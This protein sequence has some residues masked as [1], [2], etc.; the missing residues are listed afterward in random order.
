MKDAKDGAG[1][2]MAPVTWDFT[3]AAPPP[4]PPDQGPGGPVAIVTSSANPYSKYLAEILRTEG[5]NEFTT[6]DLS[7]LSAATLSDFDVVVLGS[8]NVSATQVTALTDWVNA[9]GNLIALKPDASL[10]SLLGI[11]ATGAGPAERR[12]P[13]GRQRSTAG[14]RGHRVDHDAVPRPGRP[15]HACPARRRWR[16]CTRTPPSAT[17]NPAVTLRSVGTNGGQAAAFTYD[18]PASIVAMRQGNKAWA[19]QERDGQS[20]DPLRRHVLRR[21]RQ[22]LGRPQQGRD[23]LRPTSSSACSPT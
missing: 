12:L 4:P 5:L 13:P 8:V 7:D 22:G 9:G 2:T 6:V 21:R 3:T 1:N 16:R 17:T 10:S 11:T 20:P 19:G 23:A 15:L 18:L 14:W